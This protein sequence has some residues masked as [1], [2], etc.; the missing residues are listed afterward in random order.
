MDDTS[1]GLETELRSLAESEA[2]DRR[3]AAGNRLEHVAHALE[4]AAASLE[5]EGEPRL[6]RM[7]GDL[8]DRASRAGR[9]LREHDVGTIVDEL[10][11][12]ARTNPGRFFAGTA[13]AGVLLG[14]FFRASDRDE[15]A[16][17]RDGEGERR[18]GA[19]TH[20]GGGDTHG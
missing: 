13:L 5:D 15:S 10:E 17:G 1:T 20:D 11:S 3:S 2:E 7:A 9:Y 19:G 14:R 12:R 8:A 16:S 6:G 4:G 18:D